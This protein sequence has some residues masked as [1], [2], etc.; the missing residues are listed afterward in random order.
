MIYGAKEITLKSGERC[1]LRSPDADD[2]QAM[3]D[4]LKAVAAETDYMLRY[5]DEVTM[6][7]TDEKAFI[8]AQADSKKNM[9]IAA[10]IDGKIAGNIGLNCISEKDKT[11]HRASIGIAVISE[12]WGKGI[13]S[14][15][16]NEIICAAK[17]ADYE[18]I[19]L[20]VSEENKRA[21]ALYEKLGFTQYG[22]RPNGFRLRSGKYMN[23]L[24]M[25]KML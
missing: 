19:E 13:G 24:L 9:M 6:T 12:A 11:K 17:C 18:Q 25:I 21:I 2:A 15:L 1:T 4:F 22:K 14:V 8:T 23:E 7:V 3:L 20:E 10:L 5:P 16:I